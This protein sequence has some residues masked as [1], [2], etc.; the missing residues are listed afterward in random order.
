MSL[1]RLHV[2]GT[3]LKNESGSI[4]QLKGISTSGIGWYPQYVNELLFKEFKEEWK[5]DII[6]IAMYTEEDDGYCSDGDK[7]FLKSVVDKGVKAA[8]DNDMY[9]IVDWHILSD[10]NPHINKEEA[11]KFFE[12]M[13]P[14]YV[15]YTN[16]IYEIC[17]EPNGNEVTWQVVK[18]YAKEIIPI[19]RKYD[20][21]AVIL[22]GTP[23]WSQLVLEAEKD[24]ITIDD[25]LMYVLHF[26]AGTHKDE[27]R[28]SMQKAIDKGLPIFV[29]EYG[30]VDASGNGAV[31]L[32]ETEK[33]IALMNK[34]KVSYCMWNLSNRNET[35]A[36]VKPECD[37]I[38][39]FEPDD[40]T[41]AGNWL[42]EMLTR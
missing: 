37:K 27:L 2:D 38:H 28:E 35:S 20:K 14:K 21:K 19:I 33:W 6:R 34:N 11:K 13:V 23:K 39:G 5:S 9:A 32:E 12:E 36:M 1:E 4:V 26:Y 18:E 25:N 7:E 40:L 17:N 30:I 8:A 41:P 16:V 29:S 42:K 22:V 10:N 31:N 24:R 3:F 15:D